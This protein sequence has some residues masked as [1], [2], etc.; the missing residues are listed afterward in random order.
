[1]NRLAISLLTGVAALGFISSVQA[2]DLIIS[3]PGMA[4]MWAPL[5]A[6]AGAR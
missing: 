2:A 4:S 1:M 3:E 5:P 6:M